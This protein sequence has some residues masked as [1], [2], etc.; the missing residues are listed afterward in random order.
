MEHDAVTLSP[1]NWLVGGRKQAPGFLSCSAVMIVFSIIH[2]LSPPTPVAIFPLP[3][4][5]RQNVVKWAWLILSV[6][7]FGELLL[8]MQ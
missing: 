3:T 6:F 1:V 2:E 8:E 7:Y 4:H 5:H